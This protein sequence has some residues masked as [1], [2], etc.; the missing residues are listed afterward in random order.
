MAYSSTDA[1]ILMAGAILC[2]LIGTAMWAALLFWDVE[3][4]EYYIPWQFICGFILLWIS[5]R[6]GKTPSP[7]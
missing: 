6:K 3:R 4:M 7:D 5:S 1:K 2:F